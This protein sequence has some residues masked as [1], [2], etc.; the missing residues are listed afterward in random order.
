M[1]GENKNGTPRR[2][3]CAEC[4]HPLQM[5]CCSLPKPAHRPPGP[6]PVRRLLPKLRPFYHAARRLSTPGAGLLR[7]PGA[8]G[9]QRGRRKHAKTPRRAGTKCL[10]PGS[11][12]AKRQ[13][14]DRITGT[15]VAMCRGLLYNNKDYVKK[16]LIFRHSCHIEETAVS[17][18]SAAQHS[19]GLRR[20]PTPFS[21][22]AAP[23]RG[24]GWRI[25]LKPAER[26]SGCTTKCAK[27]PPKTAG[28]HAGNG[29]GECG[30]GEPDA[31]P[32]QG[33]IVREKREE[34]EGWSR[35]RTTQG[36]GPWGCR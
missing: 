28:R 34:R 29:V 19:S 2:A 13:I 9:M 6:L 18:R 31:V 17:R 30:R 1:A 32:L 10:R 26:K 14:F 33:K 24:T 27:S 23:W 22:G 20:L 4:A 3:C 36:A 11:R 12:C 35:S 15:S 7:P 16:C 8:A 25:I 5:P 21:C